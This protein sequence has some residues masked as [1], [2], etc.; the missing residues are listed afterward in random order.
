MQVHLPGVEPSSWHAASAKHLLLY[1]V[2]PSEPQTGSH[3]S[4]QIVFRLGVQHGPG[5]AEPSYWHSV[6]AKQE[7]R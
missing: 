2:A 4:R 5:G 3:R 1:V 6:M 7:L